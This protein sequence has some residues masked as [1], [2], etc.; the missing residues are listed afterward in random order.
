MKV[1]VVGCGAAAASLAYTLTRLRPDY[2]VHVFCSGEFGVLKGSL[3]AKLFGTAVDPVLYPRKL[4]EIHGVKF[5][6]GEP[7]SEKYDVVVYCRDAKHVGEGIDPLT[8]EGVEKLSSLARG[9]KV[10]IEGFNSVS[11]TLATALAERGVEVCVECS[12]NEIIELMD[13]DMFGIVE[14]LYSKHGVK[15]GKCKDFD[16]KVSA[17]YGLGVLEYSTW[18]EADKMCCG[19]ECVY[20]DVLTGKKFS[21]LSESHAVTHASALALKLGGESIA[22]ASFRVEAAAL[23]GGKAFIVV[24]YPSSYLGMKTLS[25]VRVRTRISLVSSDDTIVKAT[26][27]AATRK[28][29]CLQVLGSVD[30]ALAIVE[31]VLSQ[32]AAC[33]LRPSP[34]IHGVTQVRNILSIAEQSILRKFLR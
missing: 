2:E 12:R 1:A 4:L 28:L 21:T 13:G 7:N 19:E 17:R 26:F 5:F 18:S 34:Y 30:T 22:Y 14:E 10:V 11:L 25:N 29:Y 33:C 32:K 15:F 3:L 16:V 9:S 6:S 23:P 8:R 20:T 24:G 31:G 27:D